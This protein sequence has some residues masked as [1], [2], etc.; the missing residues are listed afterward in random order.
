MNIKTE[1][2]TKMSLRY[3]LHDRIFIEKIKVIEKN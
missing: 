3:Y 2:V 1:K